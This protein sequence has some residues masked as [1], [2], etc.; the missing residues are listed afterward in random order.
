MS[1]DIF[2]ER[3][4]RGLI[5]KPDYSQKCYV[6]LNTGKGG[7]TPLEPGNKK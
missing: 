7:V 6:K 2:K 3:L 5:V 1:L 4:K